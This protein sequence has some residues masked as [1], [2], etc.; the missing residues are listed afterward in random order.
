MPNPKDRSDDWGLDSGLPNDCDI[1]I[2]KSRFGYQENYQNGEAALLIWDVES[3]DAD[4]Q[5]PIIW[6]VGSGWEVREKGLSIEHPKR[7]RFIATSMY[8]RLIDRADK[9]GILE[10]LR[11]K[12]SPRRADIWEGLAFHVLNEK[13]VFEGLEKQGGKG[14]TEHLFPTD[15]LGVVDSSGNIKRTGGGSSVSSSGKKSAEKSSFDEEEGGEEK[16]SAIRVKLA[17]LAKSSKD[18]TTFQKAAMKLDEVQGDRQLLAEVLDDSDEGF[19][20]KNK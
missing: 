10:I 18:S 9:L 2:T 3:P 4:F 19:Y 16:P 20:L 6:P 8:G 11:K 7:S 5:H 17:S 1:I 15:F 12:G 13:I 14:Y